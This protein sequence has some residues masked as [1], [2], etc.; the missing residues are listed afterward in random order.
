M[1]ELCPQNDF[2]NQRIA[3][4]LWGIPIGLFVV[5]AFLGPLARTLFWTPALLVA[6]T[7]CVVNARHCHRLHCYFT[8]PLFLVA[9]VVTLLRGLE[10]VALPW[11]WIGA[12]IVGGA[13]LAHVPEWI[14][15][16]Y[17][18]PQCVTKGGEEQ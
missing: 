11:V 16:K 6:G 13:A 5:G 12:A 4:V 18:T 15:G 1:T 2:V 14:N 7:A 9:A 8:G 3:W 10:V 17:R